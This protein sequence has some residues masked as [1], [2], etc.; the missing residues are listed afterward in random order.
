MKIRTSQLISFT[1][2]VSFVLALTVL[3]ISHPAHAQGNYCLRLHNTIVSPV[4]GD[5]L[6]TDLPDTLNAPSPDGRFNVA[7]EFDM[8]GMSNTAILENQA[9][10]ARAVIGQ[11][12]DRVYWSDDSVSYAFLS[13]DRP[14][15]SLTLGNVRDHVIQTIPIEATAEHPMLRLHGFSVDGRYLGLTVTADGHS[16]VVFYTIP[17]LT[18]FTINTDEINRSF[19]W[20]S[21]GHNVGFITGSEHSYQVNVLSADGEW[22]I[23]YPSPTNSEFTQFIWSPDGTHVAVYHREHNNPQTVVVSHDGILAQFNGIPTSVTWAEDDG[24]LLVWQQTDDNLTYDLVRFDVTTR[25]NE[26]LLRNIYGTYDLSTEGRLLV[27]PVWQDKLNEMLVLTLFRPDV[28]TYN[29]IRGIRP[30]PIYR[31]VR[32]YWPPVGNTA[33]LTYVVDYADDNITMFDIWIH[34]RNL[35]TETSGTYANISLP[36]W[37]NNGTAYVQWRYRNERYQVVWFDTDTHEEKLLTVGMMR[38]DLLSLDERTG[39]FYYR[40]QNEAGHSGLDLFASDGTRL[41]RWIAQGELLGVDEG[42]FPP[43]FVLSP[44]HQQVVI[45]SV[46]PD[47]GVVTQFFPAETEPIELKHTG[48]LPLHY[49]AW[50][51]DGSMFAY[52]SAGEYQ[53]STVFVVD[54]EGNLLT[55]FDQFPGLVMSGK[56]SWVVCPE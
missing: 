51:P 29:L 49:S 24:S 17:D 16:Q 45:N 28:G 43:P 11:N 40:W 44:S 53:V 39:N 33:S 46:I 41:Y 19:T 52:F 9:S 12:A 20:S 32:I 18:L 10:G 1:V 55:Q 48:S 37:I 56:M 42:G 25:Q 35:N 3:N 14:H 6:A 50:S 34:T 47:Q 38:V 13:S 54:R 5:T 22:H 4:N 8:S 36:L 31:G 30:T 23:A 21:S 27:A 26:T 7:R 2:S 15:F